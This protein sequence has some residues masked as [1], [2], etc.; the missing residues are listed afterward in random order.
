MML[1]GE[2]GDVEAAALGNNRSDWPM[3]PVVPNAKAVGDNGGASGLRV[4]A[5]DLGPLRHNLRVP[6]KGPVAE[7]G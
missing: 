1:R 2:P 6:P 3:W 7:E 5:G 4:V